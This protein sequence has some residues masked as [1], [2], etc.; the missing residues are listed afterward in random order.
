MNKEALLGYNRQITH[1]D[2]RNVNIV[3]D[4]PVQPF[5]VRKIE[6]EGMPHH[7]YSSIKGDLFVKH[8]IRLPRTLSQ[9]E[10]ELIE[11]IFRD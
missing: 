4:L 1:L 10:K 2:G 5:S 7:N 6:K 3:S 11:K 8:K 9:Q